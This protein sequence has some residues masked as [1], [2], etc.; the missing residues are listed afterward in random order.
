MSK[1]KYGDTVKIHVKQK[2]EDGTVIY[3]TENH[4]PLKFKIGEG[5]LILGL[6]NAVVGMS[7]GDKKTE[8]VPP[9]QAFG[10]RRD[11]FVFNIDR[12][13]LPPRIKP[14]VGMELDMGSS[15]ERHMTRVRII[16]VSESEVTIDMNHPLAGKSFIFDIEL[17]ALAC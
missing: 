2:L 17:L 10:L 4:N 14:K 8:K 7:P 11:K 3:S 6:E 13:W 1:A 16:D 15:E 12:N 5:R 9:E